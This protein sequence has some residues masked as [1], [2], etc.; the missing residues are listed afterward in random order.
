MS[1]KTKLLLFNVWKRLKKHPPPPHVEEPSV[2]FLI[3]FLNQS[4]CF[5]LGK[6]EN[7]VKSRTISPK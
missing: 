5:N 4:L 3:V 6:P 2:L 7:M 1:L